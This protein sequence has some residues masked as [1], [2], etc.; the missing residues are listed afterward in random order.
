MSAWPLLPPLCWRTV[1]L[2]ARRRWL[3]RAAWGLLLLLLHD[4]SPPRPPLLRPS[5]Q[6]ARAQRQHGHDAGGGWAPAA[7]GGRR[8]GCYRSG[9]PPRGRAL[10]RA[11]QP[12]CP[13]LPGVLTAALGW[14][15]CTGQMDAA[16]CTPA[17]PTPAGTSGRFELKS[18]YLPL[19]G[20]GGGRGGRGGGGYSLVLEGDDD[21]VPPV[22]HPHCC[23]DC[24][25]CVSRLR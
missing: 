11:A 13:P 9:G 15:T 17:P 3:S 24:V 12:A 25:G 20:R 8:C 18:Q 5:T 22:S 21:D 14:N 10:R 4:G 2:G 19:G 7:A 1:H 23:V 6:E 16:S